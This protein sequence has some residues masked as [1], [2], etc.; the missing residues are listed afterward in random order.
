M[1]STK[2]GKRSRKRH[3]AVARCCSRRKRDSSTGR[4]HSVERRT[5]HEL[6]RYRYDRSKSPPNRSLP[7]DRKVSP[8][9]EFT[10]WQAAQPEPRGSAARGGLHPH[11]ADGIGSQY[12]RLRGVAVA[13][14]GE[15]LW[16]VRVAVIGWSVAGRRNGESLPND[17]APR[18]RIITR[19]RCSFAIRL[20]E[21]PAPAPMPAA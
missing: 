2:S 16:S 15:S 19:P 17:V 4:S 1:V 8:P 5:Q 9:Q 10:A 11:A 20:K 14:H 7:P 13:A 18:P 6:W 12:G 3:R 21:S